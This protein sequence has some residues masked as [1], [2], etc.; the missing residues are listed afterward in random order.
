MY[1]NVELAFRSDAEIGESPRWDTRTQR[2]IWVDVNRGK[3]A[4][5]DPKLGTNIEYALGTKI[6]VAVLAEDG[7]IGLAVQ[8]GFALFD[9]ASEGLTK[10]VVVEERPDY[11]FNDGAVD[12]AGRFYAGTMRVPPV[13][14]SAHLYSLDATGLVSARLRDVGLANGMAWSLD[15]KKFYFADTLLGNIQEFEYEISDGAISNPRVLLELPEKIG[16]A[17]GMIIDSEG[18]LWLAIWRGGQ[19]WRITPKGKVITKIHLPVTQVTSMGFGGKNLDKLFITSATFQIPP[20]Q[21]HLQPLAGSI[22]VADVGVVGIEQN[23]FIYPRTS[24]ELGRFDP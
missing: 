4:F 18:C 21:L 10:L 17:D 15:N 9:E 5:F 7:L 2:L 14:Q 1:S 13:L 11:R 3:L 19:I 8:D 6:G 20:D 23:L 16:L 12:A 24:S 22:F